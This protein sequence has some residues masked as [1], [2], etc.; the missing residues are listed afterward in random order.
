MQAFPSI[1]NAWFYVKTGAGPLECINS[2]ALCG[3]SSLFLKKKN[4]TIVTER[5][6]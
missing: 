1:I 2:V 5:G 4:K 6:F 3:H